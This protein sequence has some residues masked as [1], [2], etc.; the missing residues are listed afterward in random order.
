VS[1][2]ELG[3]GAQPGSKKVQTPYLL[4]NL[5]NA[6]LHKSFKV[7]FLGKINYYV[8]EIPRLFCYYKYTNPDKPEPKDD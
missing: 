4:F 1:A 5:S 2:R 3:Q 6:S 8:V 7:F